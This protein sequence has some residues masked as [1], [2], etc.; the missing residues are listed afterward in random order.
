MVQQ[1]F[2]IVL[3]YIFRLFIICGN[4][5][6]SLVLFFPLICKDDLEVVFDVRLLFYSST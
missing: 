4:V 2:D 1:M 5:T 3:P 6:G